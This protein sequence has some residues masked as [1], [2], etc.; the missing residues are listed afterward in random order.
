MC[1]RQCALISGKI[2]RSRVRACVG[3]GGD[4]LEFM[5]ICYFVRCLGAF[6]SIPSKIYEKIIDNEKKNENFDQT[7]S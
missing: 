6:S 5:H 1:L 2:R 3:G 7:D 4:V